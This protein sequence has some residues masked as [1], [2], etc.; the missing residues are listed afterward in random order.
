MSATA[1]SSIELPHVIDPGNADRLGLTL[2]IAAALHALVILGVGF[3]IARGKNEQPPPLSM[4]VTLVHAHDEE[5]PEKA[6][7][8][9]QQ[10][11]RGAGEMEEAQRPSSP[12]PNPRPEELQGDAAKTQMESAP[13]TPPPSLDKELLTTERDSSLRA[14]ITPPEE[15]PLPEPTADAAE[16][17]ERSLEIA[18]LSAEIR[19]RQESYARRDRHKFIGANTREYK[20][21][22]YEDAWRM[23]VERIGNL[24]YP[25]EARSGNLSGSLL[26]DVAIRADGHIESIKVVRSSGIKALDD[27]AI[28]IVRLAAPFAAFTPEIRAETDVLHILRTWQFQSGSRLSTR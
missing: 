11:Q 9:A 15:Q 14:A 3:E 17:L 19:Q 20:Y 18:R 16:L 27:G 4:E 21:A 1:D 7:F 12:L 5:A 25:D 28:R 24:N 26:L 13:K 23:R 10:N 8:L 22:G 6:D 2:F